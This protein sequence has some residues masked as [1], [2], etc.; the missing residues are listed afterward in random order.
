V[1][2]VCDSSFQTGTLIG[3]SSALL[4][5]GIE[6]VGM[7][8]FNSNLATTV[9]VFQVDSASNIQISSCAFQSN[10]VAPYY[11]NLVAILSTNSTSSRISFEN[12]EFIGGGNGLVM[13][14]PSVNSVRV[15]TSSFFAQANVPVHLGSSTGYVGV[16]N[17]VD[18]G[19]TPLFFGNSMS[20]LVNETNTTGNLINT[21]GAFFGNLQISS[22]LQF[23]LSTSPIVVPLYSNVG[24]HT[25][26]EVIKGTDVRRG[27]FKVTNNLSGSVFDDEYVETA[28]SVGANLFAN[29]TS[30]LAS[31]ASGTATL[32]L[33]NIRFI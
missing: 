4:P 7:A 8:F 30:F 27:V 5:E 32:K 33:S 10:S 23:S 14:S 22:T 3:T 21:A 31:V 1:A 29:S 18:S 28:T 26:Y 24:V 25:N 13:S 15:L 2:N 17:F 9:P 20:V 19:R 12:C 6:I 16:G 11:P